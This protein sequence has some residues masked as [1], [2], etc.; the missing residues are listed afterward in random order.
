M[1][2]HFFHR[3]SVSLTWPCFSFSSRA[4]WLNIMVLTFSVCAKTRENSGTLWKRIAQTPTTNRLKKMGSTTK[5]RPLQLLLVR[6][7]I[8][9]VSYVGS[10]C[11]SMQKVFVAFFWYYWG[12]WLCVWPKVASDT[13]KLN[14]FN[15]LMKCYLKLLSGIY[16]HAPL[17]FQ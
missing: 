6:A 8:K 2:K 11:S 16:V 4:K 14:L 17:W 13:K 9:Y 7:G 3:S 15:L 5:I 10:F 12:W 1:A